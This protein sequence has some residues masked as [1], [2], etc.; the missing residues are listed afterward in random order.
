MGRLLHIAALHRAVRG[1]EP[2]VDCHTAEGSGLRGS[3]NSLPQCRGQ[4]AVRILLLAGSLLRTV[5]LPH[6][7]AGQPRGMAWVN[8]GSNKSSGARLLACSLACCVQVIV[9][10]PP[11]ILFCHTSGPGQPANQP[12]AQH[13]SFGE[14][15]QCRPGPQ[16][17]LQLS[18]CR[19]GI[20]R[21]CTSTA[22]SQ[23]RNRSKGHG[24]SLWAVSLIHGHSSVS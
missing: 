22:L 21:P 11:T 14:T 10:S 7:G 5:H 1:G 13:G 6:Q 15:V 24:S 9:H 20:P 2:S 17:G 12:A 19:L 8:P 4:S 18:C 16:G 23:H 3:F